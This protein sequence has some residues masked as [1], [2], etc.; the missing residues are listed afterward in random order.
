MP[1]ESAAAAA[2]GPEK[3][4]PPPHPPPHRALGSEKTPPS[5]QP[6]AGYQADL[7]LILSSTHMSA[8]FD[9]LLLLVF[10][11]TFL[12]PTYAGCYQRRLC[13][14]GRNA[15][16]S[17][18]EDGIAHLPTIS[19]PEAQARRVGELKLPPEWFDIEA[20]EG[21]EGSGGSGD[22]EWVTE[23]TEAPSRVTKRD[24]ESWV[25]DQLLN[26]SPAINVQHLLLGLPYFANSMF[27]EHVRY[28]AGQPILRRVLVY[29]LHRLPILT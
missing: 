25:R 22:G 23:V 11:T 21:S 9:S 5:P 10:F 6:P 20:S 26:T 1:P 7:T 29:F 28:Y 17:A 24:T 19:P 27:N 8:L 13:C 2:A 4:A 16:C 15:S 14:V 3:R 12:P 18:I